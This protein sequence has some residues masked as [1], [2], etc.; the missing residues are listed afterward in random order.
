MEPSSKSKL[1]ESGRKLFNK[2]GFRKV[3]VEEICKDAGV[4]KMTFYRFFQN[5]MEL[6]KF[7]LMEMSETGRNGYHE[8]MSLN[9]SF[10]DKV[11]RTIRMKEETA[12]Q[13]SNE[14]LQDILDDK[15][16]NLIGLIQ[17]LTVEMLE[18]V[19][20]DYRKAQLEGH[21]RK[22]LNLNIIPYF[23]NQINIMVKD[24]ALL[25]VAGGDL[26]LVMVELTNLFFYGIME[27]G[28]RQSDE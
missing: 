22:N 28:R 20:A 15:D 24:P 3:T 18:E 12:A 27:P 16:S 5:K 4:S 9:L 8:I 6:V 19:M 21:V 23:L 25:E 26:K 17:R 7:I 13:Y 11:R 1:V 2:F 14:F 10:E